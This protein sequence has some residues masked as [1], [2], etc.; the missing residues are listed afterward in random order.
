MIK[1]LSLVVVMLGLGIGIGSAISGFSAKKEVKMPFHVK[2]IRYAVKPCNFLGSETLVV[3]DTWQA[4]LVS[5]SSVTLL[6]DGL[7][8]SVNDN[9]CQFLLETQKVQVEKGMFPMRRLAG[10][11]S[12]GKEFE[13][14]GFLG[15]SIDSTK[16]E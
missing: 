2:D 7:H 15:D 6:K 3:L 12:F 10:Y 4:Y 14:L 9:K 8:T 16:G 1:T 13:Q 5:E 11:D